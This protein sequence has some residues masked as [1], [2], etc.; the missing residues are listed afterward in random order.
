MVLPTV[1]LRVTEADPSARGNTV[2]AVTKKV[3]LETGIEVKVP[4][5]IEAG[6]DAT[7][8]AIITCPCAPIDKI[9]GG[10]DFASAYKDAFGADAGTYSAEAYDSANFF[11]AGIASGAQDR[12]SLNTYVS[13]ESFAG[14]TK[15]LKFDEQGEV[16]DVAIYASTVKDGKI[17]SV[18]LIQ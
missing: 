15:T 3:K 6:G 16:S 13:T 12:D 7:E 4:G 8:G 18:G 1:T 9:E 10:A 5:Y 14:I 2:N 11:L 17:V